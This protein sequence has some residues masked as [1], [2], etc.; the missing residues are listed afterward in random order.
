MRCIYFVRDNRYAKELIQ[1]LVSHLG[2]RVPIHHAQQAVN[3]CDAKLG[4]YLKVGLLECGCAVAIADTEG[5]DPRHVADEV[6]DHLRELG[7]QPQLFFDT[8]RLVAHI[9]VGSVGKVAVMLA[10][11]CLEMW[12]GELLGIATAPT[13]RDVIT[14]LK[15]EIGDYDKKLLPK[16][17]AERLRGGDDPPSFLENFKYAVTC[18]RK[19]CTD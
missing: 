4:R 9:S 18:C 13:C 3:V 12:L 14:L 5:R 11:P 17:I 10:H 8:A 19:M 15:R 16:L 6:A 1:K 7:L 2:L